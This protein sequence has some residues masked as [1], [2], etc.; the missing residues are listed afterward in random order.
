MAKSLEEMLFHS[1]RSLASILKILQ[2]TGQ[3]HLHTAGDVVRNLR[4]IPHT[5]SPA[6][7]AA[8]VKST[9]GLKQ[10]LSSTKPRGWCDLLTADESWLSFTTSY[11]HIWIPQRAQVPTRPRQTISGEKQMLTIFWSHSVFPS[12]EFSQRDLI[13]MRAISAPRFFRR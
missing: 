3:R 5:L 2:T 4:I 9:I 1:V 11:E 13:L 7:N 10:N 12:F 6:Q 8:R